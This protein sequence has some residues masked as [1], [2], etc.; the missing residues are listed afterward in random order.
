[1]ETKYIRLD[2]EESLETKK[3]L[4]SSQLN[5][6]RTSKNLRNYKM[7]RAKEI[8]IK[9]KLNVAL[10]TLKAKINLIQSTFPEQEKSKILPKKERIIE[11]NKQENI[12]RQLEDIQCKLAKLQ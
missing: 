7:L 3:N 5:L 6:L 11:I 12:Q 9:N 2:Y 8:A 1:M 10:K 4:L